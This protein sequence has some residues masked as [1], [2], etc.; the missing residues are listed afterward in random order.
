MK[1]LFWGMAILWLCQLPAY[2]RETSNPAVT[3]LK[4]VMAKYNQP[5]Y[6]SFEMKSRF[7]A[8]AAQN[9]ESV[10]TGEYIISIF[11]E[12]QQGTSMN[13]YAIVE[14][15]FTNYA[16]E[17]F[18]PDLLKPERYIQPEGNTFVVSQLY[19]DYN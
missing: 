11:G 19:K 18:N 10:S 6:L 16:T 7:A 17:K 3:V 1:L 9:T 4:H 12:A 2:A 15:F 8:E 13:E 14:S 5:G